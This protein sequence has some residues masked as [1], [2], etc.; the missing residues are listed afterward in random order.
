MAR[1][2]TVNKTG[3]ANK[4]G[5]NH[6]EAW[7]CF[8]CLNCGATVKANIGLSLP[9]LEEAMGNCVWLCPECGYE[10]SILSDIPDSMDN[11][12]EEW[13][14][15]DDP[16][17]QGLLDCIFQNADKRCIFILEALFKMW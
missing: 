11:F 7:V 8:P 13:R 1:R 14:S 15:S 16:H 9:T 17:C 2:A 4:E 6:K 3:F 10:H 5:V 12:P